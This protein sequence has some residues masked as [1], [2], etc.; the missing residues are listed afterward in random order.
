MTYYN[1]VLE[2]RCGPG[3]TLLEMKLCLGQLQLW[4]KA[5]PHFR[6][7]KQGLATETGIGIA[8]G[9]QTEQ[10]LCKAFPRDFTDA[11]PLWCCLLPSMDLNKNC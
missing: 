1:A 10:Y 11:I 2:N 9:F 3:C 4:T 8:L 5:V 7:F 6:S